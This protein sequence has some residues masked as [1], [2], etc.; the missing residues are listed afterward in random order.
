MAVKKRLSTF[1]TILL[2]FAGLVL[3]GAFLLML[4][5]SSAEGIVTPFDEAI[6]TA[7]SASCVTGLVIHDTATYWS[8]FGQAIILILIQI[9]GLGV[10]TMAALFSILSGRKISLMQR[11]TMQEALSAHQIGGIVKLTRFILIATGIIELTGALLM[12]PSFVSRF[13]ARGIWMSFF[14]S[15]SAFCNAGF[16]VMG[17]KDQQYQSLTSF[18]G[19]PLINITVM[20]LIIIGG[21]GFLTWSDVRTNKFKLNRYTLQSKIV[22]LMAAFLIVLPAVY[23]F[24]AEYSGEP[25][26]RRILLSFFQSVTT[27]TAGFNTGDFGSMKGSS[28]GLTMALMLVGGSTGS[29]A[30]GMKT[31]TLA[32]LI[33]NGLSVFTRKEDTQLFG[34]RIDSSVVRNAATIFMMYITLFFAGAVAISFIE[35]LSFQ[36]CLFETASA[37]GTV[38]LS[39]GITPGLGIIS[40]LILVV[41]MFLG[42]VGGLTIIFSAFS[43]PARNFSKPPL[44]KITVG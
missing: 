31:T 9:G 34:R 10:V 24:F 36:K 8:Y 2:G 20:L 5:I 13:G 22:L 44:E 21:I 41:L 23:F 19:D 12:M 29:T 16:D 15:I 42:R 32:V 7:A 3:L 28:L 14:H 35:G 37:V 6:F 39:V 43:G 11:S 4:P 40:R 17:T 25:L 27:R 18:A 33:A 1:Q 26:G 38:G 30:G